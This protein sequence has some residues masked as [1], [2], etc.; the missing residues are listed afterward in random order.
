MNKKDCT[1]LEK[2]YSSTEILNLKIRLCSASHNFE[3]AEEMEQFFYRE[4]NIIS[5]VIMIE[6]TI[7]SLCTNSHGESM[8]TRMPCALL[9]TV[10]IHC[11]SAKC[12][13]THIKCSLMHVNIY[14]RKKKKQYKN[15]CFSGW[16]SFNDIKEFLFYCSTCLSSCPLGSETIGL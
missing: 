12:Y 5:P 8:N 15:N 2:I 1:N 4:I 10:Y 13:N 11:A 3:I 7:L 9:K 6:L 16:F 14:V